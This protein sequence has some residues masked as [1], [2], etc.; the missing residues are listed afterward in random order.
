M[1]IHE[2]SI[3]WSAWR[4]FW[5]SQRVAASSPQNVCYGQKKPTPQLPVKMKVTFLYCLK[6]FW[7]LTKA[8]WGFLGL[9]ITYKDIK[10]LP[11]VFVG[12][13]F[14]HN[15]HSEAC[16]GH[17]RPLVAF[18]GLRKL[19]GPNQNT[20]PMTLGVQVGPSPAG[21]EPADSEIWGSTYISNKKTVEADILSQF[22]S[23][24]L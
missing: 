3:S 8:T 20:A 13:V 21:S 17:R 19:S 4:V 15:R 7:D 5:D 22:W 18:V 11:P 23:K 2:I 6:A 24:Y 10:M 1:L 14:P 9:H 12:W 16:R